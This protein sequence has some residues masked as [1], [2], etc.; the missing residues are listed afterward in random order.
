[1]KTADIALCV[2]NVVYEHIALSIYKTGHTLRCLEYMCSLYSPL[3][4]HELWL[5]SRL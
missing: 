3:R 1:M 4:R 5:R 2:I